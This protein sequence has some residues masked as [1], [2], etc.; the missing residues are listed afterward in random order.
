MLKRKKEISLTGSFGTGTVT[1]NGV[2]IRSGPGTSYSILTTRDKGAQLEVTG[3][4]GGWYKVA[5]NG[6][7]AYI[8]S[9]YLS[10]SSSSGTSSPSSSV[11]GTGTVSGMSVRVRSG[12]GTSYSILGV[13]D[14][15]DTLSVT[16]ESGDWYQVSYNGSTGYIAGNLVNLLHHKLSTLTTCNTSDM[17]HVEVEIVEL[18]FC[19]VVLKLAPC[20]DAST[21]G[22]PS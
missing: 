15:G 22:I 8:S 16:G 20:A 17:I 18:Q 3:V 9:T 12:P 14:T 7:D 4:S 2:R 10:L 6:S 13:C 11:S 21:C 5:V 1:G 19:L